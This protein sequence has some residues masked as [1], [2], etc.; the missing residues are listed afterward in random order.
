MR[1]VADEAEALAWLAQLGA[2]SVP[3]SPPPEPV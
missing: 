1:P 2:P 3:A